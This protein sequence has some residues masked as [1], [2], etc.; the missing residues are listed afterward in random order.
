AGSAAQV[1]TEVARPEP[2][3]APFKKDQV[4]ATLKIT[5]NGQ[6]LAEVPLVALDAVEESGF[7]GRAWDAVRLWIK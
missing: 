2:L 7:L 5:Q 6:P 3:I 1:K 4:V